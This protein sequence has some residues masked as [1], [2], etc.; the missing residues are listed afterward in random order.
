MK[1]M[2]FTKVYKISPKVS[3]N[4]V[5][6]GV[7]IQTP[8]SSPKMPFLHDFVFIERSSSIFN[9]HRIQ[10]VLTLFPCTKKVEG[11]KNKSG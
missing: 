8:K 3:P 5:Q 11:P 6:K 10:E 1:S 2:T 4:I 9:F 7:N